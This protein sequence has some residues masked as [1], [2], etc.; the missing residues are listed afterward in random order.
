V[1]GTYIAVVVFISQRS[2]RKWIKIVAKIKVSFKE[3]QELREIVKRLQPVKRI[4]VAKME[5]DGFKK[6]YI[7]L[8]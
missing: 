6:A 8:K 4:K 2:G 1:A 3:D 7:E 5:H